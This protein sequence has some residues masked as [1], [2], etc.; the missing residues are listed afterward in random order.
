[1][2]KWNFFFFFLQCIRVVPFVFA[3]QVNKAEKKGSNKLVALN[4]HAQNSAM[5]RTNDEA[6]SISTTV[7][8]I[9][10]IFILFNCVRAPL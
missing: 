7:E 10:D 6:S 4:H 2:L 1:M 5:Q 9:Q 8:N 3:K